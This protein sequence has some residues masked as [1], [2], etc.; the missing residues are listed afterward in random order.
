MQFSKS[1]FFP[2]NQPAST[3]L[4]HSFWLISL[5]FPFFFWSGQSP[6]ESLS[7]SPLP[8]PPNQWGIEWEPECCL[9]K[10]KLQNHKLQKI[11]TAKNRKEHTISPCLL[12]SNCAFYRPLDNSGLFVNFLTHTTQKTI[13]FHQR[14]WSQRIFVVKKKQKMWV[15]AFPVACFGPIWFYFIL[16]CGIDFKAQSV[17]PPPPQNPWDSH[18]DKEGLQ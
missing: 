17:P 2:A 3:S 10:E 5:T 14:Q 16:L 11:V 8:L 4:E 18:W 6:R 1:C 9:C 15:Q 12:K 13:L 7:L